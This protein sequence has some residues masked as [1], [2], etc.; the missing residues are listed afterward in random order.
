MEVRLRWI[1]EISEEQFGFM[2][3][4]STTD[5]IFALRQLLAKYHEGQKKLHCVFIDLE[6]AY[7]WVWNCMRMK[8]VPE[9]FIRIMQELPWPSGYELRLSL[10]R[11]QVPIPVKVL[12][13][14]QEG[15][16]V[17]KC[18]LLQQSPN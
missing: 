13:G 8:G 5:A 16:P 17:Q 10:E 18:S 6:K 11:S 1:V 9:K 7:N 4:R 15:H 14:R 2:P 3:G 12:G